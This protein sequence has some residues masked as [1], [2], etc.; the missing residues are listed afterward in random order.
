[1]VLMQALVPLAAPLP[2]VRAVGRQADDSPV[3]VRDTGTHGTSTY[4]LAEDSR[5]EWLESRRLAR[6]TT[7]TGRLLALAEATLPA[8]YAAA[9]AVAAFPLAQVWQAFQDGK[10]WRPV[11]ETGIGL[12]HDPWESRFRSVAEAERHFLADPES[13]PLFSYPDDHG[14]RRAFVWANGGLLNIPTEVFQIRR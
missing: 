6:L 14:I 3:I 12:G 11:P 2:G 13:A 8:P 4:F 9:A 7:L 10:Y 5:A 1:M